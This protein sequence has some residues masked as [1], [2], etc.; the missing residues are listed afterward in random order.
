MKKEHLT[1][2]DKIMLA[3]FELD[4]KNQKKITVEDVAVQ[5]WKM[6]PTEFCLRGYPQYPNN[7][8]QKHIT[9]LL[10]NNLI[11]GGVFNYKITPKGKNFVKEI[12]NKENV[13]KENVSAE[14]PR[15][16]RSEINR[17]LNSKV[18][19][20]FIKN[21]QMDFLESDLFEFLGTSSRSLTTK[22]RN[23]F[24]ARYNTIIKDVIPF[25]NSVKKNENYAKIVIELWRKLQ[26][27]F[28]KVLKTK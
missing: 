7:D 15:H 14:Q 19:K 8:I 23:V 13:N 11:T 2:S 6:Y 20:Y 22:D 12:L 27:K 5:L 9:K 25:C 28:E 10:D 4:K 1:K 18:Y 17:I 3:I 21:P 24:L 16:I 26:L